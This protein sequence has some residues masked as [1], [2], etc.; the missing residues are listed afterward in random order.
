MLLVQMRPRDIVAVVKLNLA[1]EIAYTCVVTSLI[2]GFVS[3]EQVET[4]H[5]RIT[6]AE[7]S[8]QMDFYSAV[9]L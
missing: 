4:L 3:K 8:I 1:I 9:S 2:I 5:Y 7:N 6:M